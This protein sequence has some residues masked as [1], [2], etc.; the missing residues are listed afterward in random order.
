MI[1]PHKVDGVSVPQLVVNDT[2]LDGLWTL[3]RAARARFAEPVIG[4]TGS[5]GKTSDQGI[6][7]RL[8]RRLCQPEQL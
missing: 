2:L 7:R 5:A 6:H 1:V 8:P 3:A 4:L